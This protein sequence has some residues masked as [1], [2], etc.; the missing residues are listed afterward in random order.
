MPGRWHFPA[1]RPPRKGDETLLRVIRFF[2]AFCAGLALAVGL[3]LAT[4]DAAHAEEPLLSWDGPTACTNGAAV[5]TEGGPALTEYDRY[6]TGSGSGG[7]DTLAWTQQAPAQTDIRD[8]AP[9]DDWC[10][11]TASNAEGESDW[12]AEVFF[13]S[14]IADAVPNA[15][16][17]LTARP[18][19]DSG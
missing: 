12:S 19:D 15:P 5:G 7:T 4:A 11:I 14:A 8:D 2:M 3:A 13:H 10:V 16:I 1:G 9:G 18:A 6:C 17:N